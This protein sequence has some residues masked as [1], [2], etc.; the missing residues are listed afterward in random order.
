MPPADRC[1]DEAATI[2]DDVGDRCCLM[3]A[4]TSRALARVTFCKATTERSEVGWTGRYNLRE[5]VRRDQ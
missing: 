5:L 2:L 3:M 1:G 4:F